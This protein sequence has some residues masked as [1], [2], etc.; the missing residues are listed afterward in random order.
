MRKTSVS[1][2]RLRSLFS[3]IVITFI[4]ATAASAAD[5]NGNV[6]LREPELRIP[7]CKAPPNIDGI[8][9]P[10]EWQFA[11][12]VSMLEAYPC[13]WPRAMRQEQPV[14]YVFRDSEFL[15]VAMESLDSNTTGIV[16][17]CSMHDNLGIIGDDCVELMLAPGAGDRI[18]Q[19]D[20]PTY[21][22][23]FNSIGTV[24]DAKFITQLAE[25]HNSW[26][27]GAELA[28]TVE[29][30]HWVSEIKI[31]ISSISRDLPKDGDL[32]RMNFDRTFS[33]YN[34]LAWN[35]GGALNDC[36]VGGNA[37][38]DSQAAAARIKSVKP[39]IDGKLQ[40][41]VELANGTDKPCKVKT[42]LAGTGLDGKKIG[43]D[44][45]E[46]EVKPG[47]TKE[48][49]IGKGESLLAANIVSIKVSDEAGKTLYFSER[50]VNVPSPWF[51][52][53]V[54]P[55]VPLV[56][57]FP[58]FLPSL[59][60]LSVIVDWTAWAKKTSWA[61]EPPKAEIKVWKK[62]EENGKPV[63]EGTF[64][65]FKDYKG[66]WRSSTKDLP[67]G[68]YV[69][70]VKVLS[71]GKGE[72]MADCDDW[73]EKKIFDWMKNPR[74][75][76]EAVPAPYTPLEVDG[77]AVRPWG[78]AYSF[79][80]SGLPQGI[81]SQG[82]QML[83][84]EAQL[85]AEIDGRPA[86]VK[87]EKPFQFTSKKS[88]EVKGDST[89]SAGPL[90][91]KLEC[92]MEYDGFL[93]YRLT[94]GP[95]RDAVKISRL[96]L[97][98]PI[99]AKFA[100][101]YSA[102]GDTQGTCIQGDLLPDTQG[103]VFDSFN[104][105][106]SVCCSPS[107]ASLFWVGDHDV[108]FC[109]ASDSDKGWL[110]RDDAPAVEAWREGEQLVLW[111]NFVDKEFDLKTPRTLEFAFQAGPLKPLP[112]G[113]RGIQDIAHP[114]DAPVK[115]VQTGGSGNAMPGGGLCFIHPGVTPEEQKRSRDY[116]EKLAAGGD[117]MVVGYTYWPMVPK[118]FPE[119]RVF[120][121]EW[122]IDRQAWE[123]AAGPDPQNSL[124]KS[125]FF[126]D[127]KERYVYFDTGG[128]PSYVDFLTYAYDLALEQTPICGTYD[129]CGYPKPIYDEELGFGFTREDGRKIWSSGLWNYRERWK[130]AAYVNSQ[131]KRPNLLSDSQHC[132]AHF[133][134]A[135]G[136]IGMWRPC[137]HGYYNP[138]ED[139][140]NLDFYGS[141]DRYAAYNPSKQFG[142]AGQIGMSSPKG[143]Q[144]DPEVFAKDTR[145]MMMLAMLN[146]QDLGSW[147]T[148][149]RDSKV[150]G[151]LRLAR[152]RIK[153]WEKDVNFIGYWESKDL[154][155]A[156]PDS[157]KVSLYQRPDGVLLVV[158]NVGDQPV[159]AKLYP[160]KRLIEMFRYM[161]LDAET[162]EA[163]QWKDLSHWE[164]K[165]N[166]H[167][168]RLILLAVGNAYPKTALP[169]GK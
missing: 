95:D 89:L 109:Y 120:R 9:S 37:T 138:F 91:I 155:K 167:D 135:Y 32:W 6:E 59:D 64:S 166:R 74:G 113:W 136:F 115:L 143:R 18:R 124:W 62:G 131:H 99:S 13:Y 10:G 78:R 150:I 134:P 58:R 160:Q 40:M 130:R 53:R 3:G 110:I 104:S 117:K 153:P 114:T 125:R 127:D 86:E 100:Q 63:L 93:L 27:S 47:E 154:V 16:G 163:I 33:G 156:E 35:A 24:W 52:K 55:K 169:P 30:T 83:T 128:R 141:L 51:A 28:N 56:Y 72:L 61:G 48:I 44:A 41:T 147:N 106:R 142:Q 38:F 97:K 137:E 73:F 159:T 25:S 119:T 60:R 65:D 122:G 81:E 12:G 26:E 145:C 50:Q 76:G 111:L 98:L 85:L 67:E 102:A 116:L 82:R 46:M 15:Y 158:G 80:A 2:I 75:V 148:G 34:W 77:Q 132:H 88:G 157:V 164:V 11:A 133:M 57:V 39:L 107:F 151:D 165:V 140:D 1:R 94:Y 92:V 42:E 121:G 101:F 14:F 123:A 79:A 69:V 7:W 5:K 23:A 21:Y 129:D 152:N 43:E 54:A 49:N 90:K 96:R 4:L 105:T 87:I 19:Y 168:L 29:G 17:S 103:K 112:D 8:L 45:Q 70:K 31:P 22:F 84:G 162:D 118:G 108:C 126:G 144:G 139:R 66:T 149:A 71:P 20:F 36:R 146:D 68:E 161:C